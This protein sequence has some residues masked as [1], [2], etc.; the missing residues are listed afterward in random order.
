M[1]INLVDRVKNDARVDRQRRM[2][3]DCLLLVHSDRCFALSCKTVIFRRF[4]SLVNFF[5]AAAN[6]ESLTRQLYVPIRMQITPERL[7]LLPIELVN[8]IT[9]GFGTVLWGTREQ[10]GWVFELLAF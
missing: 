6:V 9:L 1:G 7:L 5:C 3:L 4:H 8:V 10:F 2:L